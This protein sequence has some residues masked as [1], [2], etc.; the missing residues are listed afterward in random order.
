MGPW[1]GAFAGQKLSASP[2]GTIL[3]AVTKD[4]DRAGGDGYGMPECPWCHAEGA[5]PRIESDAD[6]RHDSDCELVLA[7]A[8]L[9]ESED[10][11]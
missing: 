5:G 4:M 10:G 8:A 7:R 11:T 1:G 2:S 3:E 6:V 9:A